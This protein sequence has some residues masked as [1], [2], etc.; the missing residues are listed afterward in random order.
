MSIDSS[1]GLISGTLSIGDAGSSPYS[2][3]VTASAGSG[4]SAL[5]FTWSVATAALVLEGVPNQEHEAGAVVK[6][7]VYASSQNNLSLSYSASGLPGGLSIDSSTGLISGTLS[8]TDTLHGLYTPTVSVSSGSAS[9]SESF[10]WQVD[11][12][13][14]NL[15]ALPWRTST[16][17]SV[18]SVVA[19][20][21]CLRQRPRRGAALQRRRPA[22]RSEHQPQHGTSSAARWRWETPMAAASTRR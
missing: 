12:A 22:A 6:L 3:A 5:S 20:T 10:A 13:L 2:V 9:A 16:E 4:S 15:D 18:V 8:Q 1:T 17:G 11:P 21:V 14:L 19:G 7:Q